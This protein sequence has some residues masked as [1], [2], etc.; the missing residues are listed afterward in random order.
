MKIEKIKEELSQI[1]DPRRTKYGNIRHKLWEILAI[2]LLSTICLGED[3]DD[4][5]EF[6]KEREEWLK[7]ELGFELR[8]GVPSSDT[9]ERV[10]KRIKPEELRKYLN[11]SLEITREKG[12]EVMSID[13]KTVRGSKGRN[14]SALHVISAFCAENQ[15]VL[16]EIKSEKCRT[17][18]KEI[19]AL[20]E[21]L[22]VREAI[23]TTDSIGCYENTVKAIAA[24]EGDDVIGRKKNQE[25]LHNSV[26]NHF[27]T[28]VRVYDR[29]QTVE[30]GHGRIEVRTYYL[31]TDLDWLE[32]EYKWA[33]LRGVGMVDSC[34]LRDGKKSAAE[35]RYYITSLDNAEDFAYAVR[36][37]WAIENNL[38]WC[39]DMIFRE[40]SCRVRDHTAALNLNILRKT[41]LQIVNDADLGKKIGKR[42]KMRRSAMN[43]EVL[44][45]LILSQK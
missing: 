1:E 26:K 35:T 27:Q 6:G 12:G 45:S 4:M 42:K 38:H 3:Y 2:G 5:E 20:I 19:P 30:N 40:D 14:G 23:V 10:I 33:G 41:A 15:L 44:L 43:P 7:R 36:R 29:E 25:T 32:P 18:I 22:D 39:L 31:E 16:G 21:T 13:G 11:A 9:Y 24:G 37:H 28:G 34:V 8:Y 17:E